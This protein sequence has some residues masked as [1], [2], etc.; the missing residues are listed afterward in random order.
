MLHEPPIPRRLLFLFMGAG[1]IILGLLIV[2]AA[3]LRAA[4]GTRP[5][6]AGE[7]PG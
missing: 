4:R 2:A 3:V 5:R 1:W 7:R 6:R